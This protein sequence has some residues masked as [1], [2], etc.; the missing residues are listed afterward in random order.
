MT[1]SDFEVSLYR[2]WKPDKHQERR[3]GGIK[4][5][6]SRIKLLKSRHNNNYHLSQNCFE[7]GP[8]YGWGGWEGSGLQCRYRVGWRRELHKSRKKGPDTQ[9]LGREGSGLL[10]GPQPLTL[11]AQMLHCDSILSSEDRLC[12][13]EDLQLRDRRPTERKHVSFPSLSSQ[14]PHRKTG[15]G[16]IWIQAHPRINDC[17]QEEYEVTGLTWGVSPSHWRHGPDED[18]ILEE[19]MSMWEDRIGNNTT[20]VI[21]GDLTR[22]WV[23]STYYLDGSF[24]Q[25]C[26]AGIFIPISKIAQVWKDLPSIT[27]PDEGTMRFGPRS[28]WF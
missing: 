10:Q 14:I 6:V 19:R 16:L 25:P 5:W 4:W 26:N 18:S 3:H 24:Q 11:D 15:F 2:L 13:T 8:A 28:I 12:H 1:F 17:A 20:A 22:A 27:Q 21:Y 9:A 23:L 7:S